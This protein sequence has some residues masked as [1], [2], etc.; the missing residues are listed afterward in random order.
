MNTESKTTILR[1][2]KYQWTKDLGSN[3][4]DIINQEILKLSM[5]TAPLTDQDIA[6]SQKKLCISPKRK[7]RGAV[8]TGTSSANG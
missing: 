7:A 5:K 8:A 6:F 2:L 4:L 1:N 3:K